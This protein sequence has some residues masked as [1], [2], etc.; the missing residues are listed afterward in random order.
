MTT[1]PDNKLTLRRKRL[2]YLAEH[3]GIKKADIL[4]GRFVDQNM[5]GFDDRDVDWFET[6]F[7]E[8]DVDIIAWVTGN[9]PAP[10]AFN[11]PMMD[12]M[13][14]LDHMKK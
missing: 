9:A 8:Q 10:A 11:T 1:G 13:K 4:L 6:L 3:R 5:D 2:K 7:H 14:T 12:R